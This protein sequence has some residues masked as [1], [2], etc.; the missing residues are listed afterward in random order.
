MQRSRLATKPHRR[1]YVRGPHQ[2]CPA[3][4][5]ISTPS[6]ISPGL[7]LVGNARSGLLT[8]NELDPRRTEE[9]ASLEMAPGPSVQGL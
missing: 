5:N 9:E 1:R 8:P 2:T 6:Q 4:R 3:R 7:G